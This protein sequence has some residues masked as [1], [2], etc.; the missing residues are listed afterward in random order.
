M[1]STEML[2]VYLTD[3]LAGSAAAIDHL[4]KMISNSDGTLLGVFLAEL[5]RD[6]K[7][8]RDTLEGLIGRLGVAK[9]PVKQAA[10]TILEK[11]GRLKFTEQLSGSPQLRR[12]LELEALQLGV[13]GKD[14]MWRSLQRVA[15]TDPRLAE[16]DFEALRRRARQQID[17]LERHRLDAA[18]EAF[19]A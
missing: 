8:D 4:E 18:A 9:S 5:L 7:A 19:Q 14:A 3:H 16:V 6:I 17:A 11:V 15:H 12:L 1:S 2:G 10:A 13:E